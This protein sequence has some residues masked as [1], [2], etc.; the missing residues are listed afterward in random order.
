[1]KF[2][3]QFVGLLMVASALHGI[4]E[5]QM[6]FFE[7]KIRP[8]LAESCYECHNSVHK[9]KAGLALD[10]RDALLAGSEDGDV[11]VA[12]DPEAS[13]LIWAIR[14]QDGYEMPETGPKLDED[15]IADFEEWVRMGAPDPRDKKPTQ[16]DLDNAVPWETLLEK[17]SEWWSFQPLKKT[18]PPKV[19]N[20]D[21]NESPIDRFV[22]AALREQGLTAQ[23]IARPEVLARRVHLV[24]TGLPPEPE[25]VKAFA[26]DPSQTAYQAMVDNLLDSKS[27]GER[28][29]RHWMDWYR[30]AESHGSEGDP[31]LPYA[32]AYRDY[33]IRALNDDVPYNQLLREHI[34]G[35]LIPGPRINKDL[36]I[37]ESAIGPAHFRMVPHGFGVTDAY[38]EHITITDN[39]IDVISKAMLGVTVSC[40]RCHNHKF[41]P[42]SQKDFYRFY[43]IMASTR[44]GTLNIDTPEKQEMH[45][46]SLARMKPGIRRALADFWLGHV[47]G[48]VDQLANFPFEETS[49]ET[50]LIK[51]LAKDKKK[52]KLA[53]PSDGEILNELKV[54]AEIGQIGRYH[55]FVML[56]DLQ[57]LPTDQLGAALEALKIEYAE[58]LRTNDEAKRTATFYADLREQSTYDRWYKSGNGL[59]QEV[60]PAGSFAIAG[61]GDAAIT[62]IYPA[63]VYTHLISSKHNA[64]LS[65]PYHTAKGDFSFAMAVGHEGALRMSA[66]NYPLQQG[67]HHYDTADN[68]LMALSRFQKYAFW[69]DEIVHYQFNTAN[70]RPVGG[71]DERSWFGVTEVIAGDV[72]LKNLGSPLFTVLGD[73]SSITSGE[74]LVEAY[75]RGLHE[76]ILAWRR[77]K[78]SD[79]QSEFLSAFVRFDFLPNKLAELPDS[80]SESIYHYRALENEIPEPTRAPGLLEG[81][82]IEQPLLVRGDYKH[83]GEEAPRQFLEVFSNKAYSKTNSGRLELAEDIVGSKNTLAS[84]VL[85][86]RLWSYIFGNGIVTSTDNFGRLGKKPTH[87]E[88]LDYL[89][90][91]L[92][93]NGWSIKQALR[94]MVLS[95]TFRSSSSA[96]VGVR[97]V[98]PEN[99]YLSYF[100][101]RRLDAEA[102]MDSLNQLAFDEFER[103]VYK[104]VIR[105]RL[106]PFLSSFNYPIPTSTV[107]KRDST[108]VPAQALA[109][110]NGEFVQESAALCTDRVESVSEGAPIATKIETLFWRI[111]SRE[112]NASEREQLL[113]Y[114]MSINDTDTALK[115]V[116]LALLNTKE[117]IYVY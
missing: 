92:E 2:L 77:S 81:D 93:K 86:N 102:I 85:V 7:N 75:K 37:N 68:G 83:P 70:D 9:Q 115:N 62:G 26:K 60:S 29:A 5:E 28:W 46:K 84:R 42:I 101:P 24:L 14:H 18:R 52:R 41:D 94:Q 45:K 71:G 38:Q 35:D 110:M 25:V 44:P 23:S 6:E 90:M 33:L 108:N 107:S 21:W 32:N 65:S 104:P 116:A 19:E 16:L 91:D 58:D 15:V 31:R 57:Q 50:Q 12:G 100:T 40:A 43:G 97:E 106:D 80:I 49:E 59:S 72:A 10:Y 78:M 63:G 36:G 53:I 111:F 82:V 51:E 13:V 54:K 89:A 114:Y 117:F 8:V 56:R 66:R 88:L 27:F 109:M 22:F 4:S 61:E 96:P 113:E 30:Y 39:Q 69:N 1:M 17:R 73:V 20:K 47:D 105:N 64:T 34:A 48:A 76:S 79:A 103:S 67:L 95:R 74:S 99:A 11:I 112:P 87:P 98:D 55:P 3:P